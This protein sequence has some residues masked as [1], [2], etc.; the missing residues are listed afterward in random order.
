MKTLLADLDKKTGKTAWQA[1][2]LRHGIETIEVLVPLVNAPRFEL[3]MQRPHPS[4]Q[5]VLET[6]RDCG[7]ELK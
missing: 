1:Y 2:T 5:A 6:L 3:Q 4:K 7:G